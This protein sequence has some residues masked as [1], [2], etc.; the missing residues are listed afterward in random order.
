VTDLRAVQIFTNNGPKGVTYCI[1]A[2]TPKDF[3][4][5]FDRLTEAGWIAR[6]SPPVQGVGI[7]ALFQTREFDPSLSIRHARAMGTGAECR[8]N[9]GVM[10][11][12]FLRS[13]P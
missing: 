13:L 4:E 3:D 8:G 5:M 10:K 1:R 9:A 2:L 6:I 7:V 12:P 11:R